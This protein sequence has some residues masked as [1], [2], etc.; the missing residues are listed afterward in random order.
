MARC[1]SLEPFLAL[2]ATTRRP[3]RW[4]LGL[5]A[6]LRCDEFGALIEVKPSPSLGRPKGGLFILVQ[7]EQKPAYER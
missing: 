5:V 7:S 1:L 6:A 3:A 4:R 2:L